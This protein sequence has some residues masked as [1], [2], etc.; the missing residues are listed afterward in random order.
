MEISSS[1]STDIKALQTAIANKP[2]RTRF[3]AATK[4]L[5]GKELTEA[6][7]L[8]LRQFSNSKKQP[9]STSFLDKD[10]LAVLKY[11]PP[12]FER[13]QKLTDYQFTIFPK[14]YNPR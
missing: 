8:D 7:N 5:L 10:E 3:E 12:K 11:K 6:E 13:K 9:I 4:S 2:F 14:F 1:I